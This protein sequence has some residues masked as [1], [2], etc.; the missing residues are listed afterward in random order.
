MNEKPECAK[1]ATFVCGTEHSDKGPVNCPTR[2]KR[3]V[4]RRVLSEY[5]KPEV[6]EF[7]RQASI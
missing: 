6:R 5:D 3:D 1:C 2:A 7:A 4:I